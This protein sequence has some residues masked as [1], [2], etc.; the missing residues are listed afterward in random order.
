[1]NTSLAVARR[2][3]LRVRLASRVRTYVAPAATQA[4]APT[5]PAPMTT[6]MPKTTT[7]S[8]PTT[9]AFRS[10]PN[11]PA[12]HVVG[13]HAVPENFGEPM[14]EQEEVL[15]MWGPDVPLSRLKPPRAGSR[16]PSLGSSASGSSAAMS[17][18]QCRN[19]SEYPFS[20]LVSELGG[21][22]RIRVEQ[23]TEAE[24]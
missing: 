16:S 8:S 9:L 17:T 11:R 21:T 22:R 5:T 19:P 18:Q 24:E 10:F 14:H 1:M 3:A 7:R 15:S 23:D 12:H 6:T 4:P 20:G 2:A 13:G